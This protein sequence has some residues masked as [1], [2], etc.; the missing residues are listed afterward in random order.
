MS[1]PTSWS[2]IERDNPPPR[3]KSCAAC[4]KAKRRCTLEFPACLRCSQRNME[5][6]YP[7]GAISRRL[8]ARQARSSDASSP[9]AIGGPTDPAFVPSPPGVF[10][11][12][13]LPVS[14]PRMSPPTSQVAS[15]DDSG[16]T[17][18]AVDQ[19]DMRYPAAAAP[20]N[21]IH[22]H[23]LNSSLDTSTEITTAGLDHLKLNLPNSVSR[24]QDPCMVLS[25]PMRD[26][27]QSHS[28]DD[29]ISFAIA[30]RLQYAID[31]MAFAVRQM[32]LECET[33]WCHPQLYRHSMP[34]AIQG[35]L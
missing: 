14:V 3:R 1:Q 15:P 8:Q 25:P 35:M 18:L 30:T 21:I 13:E 6:K 22:A 32:V 7:D 33:P 31:K 23:H 12:A 27:S 11:M 5:C 24:S 17:G 10:P 20:A 19:F 26:K 2:A 34:R 29:R 9:V 4:I 16:Q 28:I